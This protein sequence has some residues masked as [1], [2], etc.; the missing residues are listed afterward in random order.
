MK[1]KMKHL[2]IC[3]PLREWRYS[4]GRTCLYSILLAIFCLVG[5]ASALD[6]V[7][8]VT[9]I[10]ELQSRNTSL[11]GNTN[12]YLV[13]GY[14]T[15]GDPGGGVF[16]WQPNI[17]NLPDGGTCLAS[18]NQYSATGRWMRILNGETANIKMW[19]AVGDGVADDSVAISNAVVACANGW[20][21]ELVFPSGN[22][23]AA[24]NINSIIPDWLHIL[25]DGT[26]NNDAIIK[27]EANKVWITQANEVWISPYG[28]GGGSGTIA[29]PYSTPNADS[30]FKLIH[31]QRMNGANNNIVIPE[32]S[33]IHLMPGVFQVCEGM[34]NDHT[35]YCL[36]PK[37]GWKIR[38]A[39]VDVT[40]LQVASTNNSHATWKSV[41][42][43]GTQCDANAN[44]QP[45]I[46][47]E[48]SD[49]TIDC[50]L[51]N[52]LD[53]SECACGITLYGSDNKI[54][55]VRAINWGT[56]QQG[57]ECFVFLVGGFSSGSHNG[58]IEDCVVDQPAVVMNKDVVSAF[59]VG[60]NGGYGGWVIRG[61]TVRNI[62]SY[63]QGQPQ[64][65]QPA[66]FNA[67]GA[68][69]C[70]GVEIYNN[71]ALNIIGGG[72]G[73]YHDSGGSQ[74][75]VF[76][77]NNM[78]LNVTWGVLMDLQSDLTFTNIVIKD[79]I[80][81]CE[82]NG[83]GIAIA[84]NE[85]KHGGPAMQALSIDGNVISPANGGRCNPLTLSAGSVLPFQVSINNN[86]LES[87]N[88]S[89]TNSY[90]DFFTPGPG[91][92]RLNILSFNNNHNL[93]GTPLTLGEYPTWRSRLNGNYDDDFTVTPTSAGWWKIFN[94]YTYTTPNT[95]G[96]VNIWATPSSGFVQNIDF[97]LDF[98]MNPYGGGVLNQTYN[99]GDSA[100]IPQVR[101]AHYNYVGC[102]EEGFEI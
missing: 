85:N 43:S 96:R 83:A 63:G 14:Y 64:R 80:I 94:V 42:I 92:L 19:G 99:D 58:L 65:G 3:N 17:S 88:N 23:K 12:T 38:G 56:L 52:Q 66:N 59:S 29:D 93:R 70:G 69:P 1:I 4:G 90:V 78:F 46:D 10:A 48:V 36:T 87:G 84:A 44:T 28:D 8:A 67:F 20:A 75:D 13:L 6:Y 37:N 5:R 54:S 53:P 50:N 18:S 71:T 24:T 35:R 62:T 31:G 61:C 34:V 2:K 51:Q 30:F 101:L 60:D 41:V 40:I 16:Q 73:I 55:R 21:T 82:N 45:N 102:V 77:H 100:G 33:T 32:Y 57:A 26:I 97:G 25:G 9:N 15:S 76:I 68:G 11:L 7:M 39:G 27:A 91:Y 22:Y 49:L 79:N 86:T 95:S 81:T 89:G 98:N 72:R 47:V 74:T